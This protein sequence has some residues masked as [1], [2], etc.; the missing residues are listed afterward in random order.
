[1]LPI[2]TSTDRLIRML[3][4]TAG[5]TV[6]AAAVV[7][8][9]DFENLTA[10]GLLTSADG[11]VTLAWTAV[12]A[13]WEVEVQQSGTSS[14]ADPT[15]RYRGRDTGSVLTGLSEGAHFYRIRVVHPD[16][17][18]G[19]WTEAVQAEV[20]FMERG[21]LFLL[22]GLGAVVVLATAGAIIGGYLSHRQDSGGEGVA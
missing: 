20:N 16:G 10:D 14:F 4:L 15:I 21:R 17:L 9:T 11:V 5:V 6:S 12:P 3:L 22:L 18:T 19:A 2:L 1:M 8:S 13:P 7:P